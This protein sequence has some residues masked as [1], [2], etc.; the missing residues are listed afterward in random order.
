[1][2]EGINAITY[3]QNLPS[4][5]HRYT[6]TNLCVGC[7]MQATASTGSFVP[8]GRRTTTSAPSYSVVSTNGVT[9]TVD[10]V[11]ACAQCHGPI[12]SFDITGRG[13]QR[14]WNHRR[15]ANGG[16]ASARRLSTLLPNAAYL[17]NG[18][19]VADGLVKSPSVKTNWPT[20][21]LNAAYNWQ[22]VNNDSSKGVHNAPFATGLLKASIAD[23]SGVSA[24]G[25]LLTPGCSSNFGSLTNLN[26]TPNAT[27][28][29]DGVPEWLKYALGLNPN[30]AGI[31]ISSG[32]VL[33]ERQEP[34]QPGGQ[35]GRYQ[36]HPEIYHCCWKLPSIPTWERPTKP[37]V[38][39]LLGRWL[40]KRECAHSG[41]LEIPS[42]T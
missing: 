29:G 10:L 27:P 16:A 32:V 5:A 22:F 30:V 41:A 34:G 6:V 15:R 24:A 2:I 28:A 39:L 17:S 9:N 1:M 37:S 21:F 36:F 8:E 4:S 18:N 12:S 20:K 26:A 40:D 35:S 7:H 3:G 13:L 14:R 23:L 11:R 19:Y 38:H 42:A 25:G 33:G 31:R